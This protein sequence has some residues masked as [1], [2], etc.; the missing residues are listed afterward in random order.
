MI[1]IIDLEVKIMRHQ[2]YSRKREAIYSYLA[3]VKTHPSAETVYE[4]LKGQYPDLSLGT[5]YRNL[6]MFKNSGM[7]ASVGVINGEERF[8]FNTKPHAHF[9]CKNCKCVL[10]L[11]DFNIDKQ[12]DY[13]IAEQYGLDV[14][15][16]NIVF[17]GRCARCKSAM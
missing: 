17:Y 7:I 13:T 10:D 9:V 4:A 16:H 5:V 6:A 2:N 12:L 15:Y 11:D 3:S 8:D 14:D 1:I